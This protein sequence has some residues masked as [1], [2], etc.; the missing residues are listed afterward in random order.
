MKVTLYGKEY[1]LEN[2][3]CIRIGGKV[4]GIDRKCWLEVV[5]NGVAT[6]IEGT[7]TIGKAASV[8]A[9]K[10]IM[11]QLKDK[12]SYVIDSNKD[13]LI[14]IDKAEKVEFYENLSLLGKKYFLRI[15]LN[16]KTFDTM[17][18]YNKKRYESIEEN[19]RRKENEKISKKIAEINGEK[20][21]ST[22]KELK[23][24]SKENDG[25]SN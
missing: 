1:E 21:Y 2:I 9:L 12:G 22:L 5:E 19:F 24:N 3:D 17:H 8:E 7:N 25:R 16:G 20:K 4:I 14:N 6:K 13:F 15:K 11:D 23:S 10:K 18:T